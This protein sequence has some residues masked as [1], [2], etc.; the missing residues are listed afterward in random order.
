MVYEIV[1][2]DHYG[3][4]DL[5][6]LIAEVAN[7]PYK[8]VGIADKDWKDF[9]PTTRY[10][11]LPFVKI[12]DKW[13]LYQ[14]IAISRFFAQEGEGHLYPSDRVEATITEEYVAALE[15]AYN[16]FVYATFLAPEDRKEEETKRL[17]EGVLT[18]VFKVLNAEL[19]KNGG[20][21]L[22]GG[23]LTWA[24]LYFVEFASNL[25]YYTKIDPVKFAPQIPKLRENVLKHPRAKAYLESERNLRKS[26]F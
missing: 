14:S 4:V 16:Q 2:F 25:S 7:I 8:F 26:V 15:D 23:K 11:L 24:D 1:Y 12:N 6:K 3:R 22:P 17:T 13:T 10:G 5:V 18:S 20:Y 19:E 9:Q 21:L